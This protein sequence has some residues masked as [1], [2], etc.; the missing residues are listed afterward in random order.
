MKIDKENEKSEFKKTTAEL[1][2]GDDD[3]NGGK[4]GR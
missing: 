2:V 1:S 3:K 4:D